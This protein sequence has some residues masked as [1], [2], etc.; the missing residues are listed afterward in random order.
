MRRDALAVSSPPR[1]DPCA[2][3]P[4]STSCLA[5]ALDDAGYRSRAA[6]SI[7]HLRL[8]PGQVV[9][10]EG[11][12]ADHVS[13]IVSGVIACS[14][15]LLDGRRQ[16]TGFLF[17]GDLLGHP[18]ETGY[19]VTAQSVT[20]VELCRYPR[21][22]FEA[23]MRDYPDL[24]H[25]VVRAMND[26]LAEAQQHK[27]TLGRR[28]AKERLACFL[29]TL[30]ERAVRRGAPDD[31]LHLPMTRSDIADHLGITYETV[32]RMFTLLKREALI[33]LPRPDEVRLLDVAELRDI[34]AGDGRHA[35]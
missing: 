10:V 2:A 23:L 25:E 34:A 32:S 9:F 15:E 8:G 22:A 4:V 26:E 31:V 6:R 19:Q 3:C 1:P 14:R 24:E 21:T 33:A 7:A 17:P 13:V 11:E 35:A 12:P 18:F 28:G 27:L 29:I 30:A 16:I 5:T 20:A